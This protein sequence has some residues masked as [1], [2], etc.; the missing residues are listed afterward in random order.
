MAKKEDSNEK[1]YK[2]L[3]EME[4]KMSTKEDLERFATKEDLERLAT[5]E[6]LNNMKEEIMREVR[7]TVDNAAD[8]VKEELL[9]EIKPMSKAQDKDSVTILNQGKQLADHTRRIVALERA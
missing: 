9:K 3:L 8:T 5:K 4:Q 1:I 6:D 7:Q 2:L